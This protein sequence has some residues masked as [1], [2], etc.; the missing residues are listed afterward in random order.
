MRWVQILSLLL[1]GA[2]VGGVLTGYAVKQSGAEGHLWESS[3]YDEARAG[4][5][6]MTLGSLKTLHAGDI[7]ATRR[8]LEERLISQAFELAGIR[9]SGHDPK[10][11][12]SKTLTRIR[13]Y[14]Q[15]NPWVSG[16]QQLDKMAA[17]ALNGATGAAGG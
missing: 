17:D 7:D 14:R 3:Q 9:K 16:N 8:G 15:A 5:A 10:G 6:L 12:I 1:A 2:V 4:D 13:E 11:D